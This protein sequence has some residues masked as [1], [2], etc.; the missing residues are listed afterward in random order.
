MLVTWSDASHSDSV[1]TLEEAAQQAVV[2]V[3]T[4][5]YLLQEYPDRLVL[6]GEFFESEGTYRRLFAIPRVNITE[7]LELMP[8]KSKSK[9]YPTTKGHPGKKKG[10]KGR[11]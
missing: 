4:L 6:A 7:V 3:K 10:K 2:R 9:N 5:G 1:S 8:H 11:R